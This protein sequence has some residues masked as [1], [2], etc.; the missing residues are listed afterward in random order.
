MPHQG[1]WKPTLNEA[2]QSEQLRRSLGNLSKRMAGEPWIS[3]TLTA[4]WVN[5]GLGYAPAGYYRDANGI[6]HLRGMVKDGAAPTTVLFQLPVGY[7][8]EYIVWMGVIAASSPTNI[9]VGTDGW[10][11]HTFGVTRTFVSLEGILFRAAA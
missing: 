8:P 9:Q 2:G 5:Y 3:P 4:T 1:S 6:V 11:A 10:V 7:R